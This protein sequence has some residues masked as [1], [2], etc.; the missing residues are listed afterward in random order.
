MATASD[1]NKID[2]MQFQ[3]QIVSLKVSLSLP[4]FVY[5]NSATSA[6]M[7]SWASPNSMR[8]LS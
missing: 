8:V 6:V 2:K 1:R 3:R 7:L 5:F 4:Y